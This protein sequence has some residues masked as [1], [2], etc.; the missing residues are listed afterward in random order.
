MFA[1]LLRLVYLR[2]DF[3]YAEH[4]VFVLHFQTFTL[5][6]SSAMIASTSVDLRSIVAGINQ[7]YLLLA[8]HRVHGEGW[9]KTVLRWIPA[10]ALMLFTE[11]IVTALVVMGLVL[12]A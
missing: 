11:G 5:V 8:L 2:R 9:G 3:R 12:F 1:A 7:L 10:G 6:T 4:F